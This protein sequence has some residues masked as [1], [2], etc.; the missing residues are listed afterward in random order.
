MVSRLGFHRS[1][2]VAGLL[3][4]VAG[5]G[6]T[7]AAMAEITG[8]SA[9]RACF[10]PPAKLPV[11]AVNAFLSRPQSLLDDNPTGGLRLS[12]ATRSLAGSS[13]ATLDVLI[14]LSSNAT[15]DQKAAIG[16][17]L[18][19]AAASC[20]AQAAE[21][22]ALI[23]QKIA[24]SGSTE[25]ITAFVSASNQIQTAALGGQAGSPGAA[26]APA[27]SGQ[28][29]NGTSGAGT[30]DESTPNT[31]GDYSIAGGGRSLVLSVSQSQ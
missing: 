1:L 18:A 5:L 7:D 26:A 12:T 4:L 3:G 13:E 28:N 15:A 30:G 21:Y 16:S 31:S 25:L 27:I 14:T 2:A 10:L 6:L 19:R 17:G 22:A 29:A 8:S 20:A 11:D 23:Q 24:A 9:D